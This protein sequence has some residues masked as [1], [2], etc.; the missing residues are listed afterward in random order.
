MNSLEVLSMNLENFMKFEK[1][2]IDFSHKTDLRGRNRVGKSTI[3]N[4][5][6]W[7][8]FNTTPDGKQADNVRPLKDGVPVNFVDIVAEIT[9][10]ING[11]QH[12]I[13]KTQKQKW[14]KKR[15]GGA[16]REF[17]GNVSE[18]EIDGF[19]YKPKEY[20]QFLADFVPTSTFLF[21]SN[22]QKFLTQPPADQRKTLEQL[23]GF[24]AE[25][26]ASDNL[27]F[28]SVVDIMK[29]HSV[30]DTLKKLKKDKSKLD[31]EIKEIPVR[32]DEA[33]RVSEVV[34]TEGI[35]SQISSIKAEIDD[36]NLKLDS[37]EKSME[38]VD[39]ARSEILLLKMEKSRI[40]QDV[41][42]KLIQKKREITRRID[43]VEYLKKGNFEKIT[44]NESIIKQKAELLEKKKSQFD[45][46]QEGWRTE[47]AKKFKE[48]DKDF[49]CP[50]CGSQ[51]PEDQQEQKVEELKA[52]FQKQQFNRISE[53][54][55]AGTDAKRDMKILAEDIDRLKG[56]NLM[57]SNKVDECNA[58]LE[59]VRK[60]LEGLKEKPD[61]SDNQEYERICLELTAKEKALEESMTP[62]DNRDEINAEKDTAMDK[63]STWKSKKKKAIADEEERK[64]RV[65][66][67]ESRLRELS[68]MVSD[69]ERQMNLVE[70]FGVE[71]NLKLSEL[72]NQNFN[73]V[74]F[75]FSRPL[76]NGGVE[77]CCQIE[78][79][80]VNYYQTLNTG[81]KKLAEIDL[82]RGFQKVNDLKLPIFLDEASEVDPDRIPEL[83]QQLITMSRTGAENLEVNNGKE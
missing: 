13:K 28:Q 29:G 21:C 47:K 64:K 39:K 66:E 63:L 41:T 25:E 76:I 67:L 80:G 69:I 74:K 71:K 1:Q 18:F 50:M 22:P 20:E 14:V 68:Q 3:M 15:N 44:L 31:K 33:K 48:P 73:I 70:K 42:D 38:S 60:S 82:V 24:N 23:F 46:M 45:E 61:M 11:K 72:V 10:N 27:E 5:F 78:I 77:D 6:Y 35:E 43:D 83:E 2:H 65:G 8:F 34:D 51:L 59:K 16:D 9:V 4:A 40:E 19:P 54:E 79:D 52:N 62:A 26:F 32:I 37:A 56:E 36:I 81:D 17:E 30:E 7:V 53:L 12:V 55:S 49:K 57:L 75:K 58:E